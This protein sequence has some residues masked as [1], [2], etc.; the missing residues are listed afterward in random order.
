V[1]PAHFAHG[2]RGGHDDEEAHRPPA[3]HWIVIEIRRRA[4]ESFDRAGQACRPP[5]LVALDLA[6]GRLQALL[7]LGEPDQ[8]QLDY[9]PAMADC[10]ELDHA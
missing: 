7:I 2:Y 1:R 8:P 3:S 5:R 9:L 4:G 6:I 10:I